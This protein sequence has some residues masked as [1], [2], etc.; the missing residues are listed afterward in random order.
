[1][2]SSGSP[3]TAEQ[4]QVYS[5]R[6]S[7]DFL[8]VADADRLDE[9]GDERLASGWL[10]CAGAGPDALAAVEERLGMTLPPGYSA[11]LQAVAC[12]SV[13]AVSNRGGEDELTWLPSPSTY[14][15][16]LEII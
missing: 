14:T 4:W 16:L 3:S 6:Y 2:T 5:A 15:A 8:R 1:M 11:F 13:T 10:G 7:A 9:L 12:R